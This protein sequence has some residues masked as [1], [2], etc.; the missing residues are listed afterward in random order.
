MSQ[1]KKKI[2]SWKRKTTID[3]LV[4]KG[5]KVSTNIKRIWGVLKYQKKANLAL[6]DH[7]YFRL[8]VR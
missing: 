1:D 8:S 4:S 2:L 5:W 6:R 7:L 3:L